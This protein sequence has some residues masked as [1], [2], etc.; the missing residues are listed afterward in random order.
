[1]KK[2]ILTLMLLAGIA[3]FSKDAFE[4]VNAENGTSY[5]QINENM[6]SF[7]FSPDWHSLGNAGRVG[8]VIYPEGLDAAQRKEY[9]SQNT[10]N[11]QF[12]KNANS[13]KIS[14]GSVSAGDRIGFYEVRPNGGTHTFTTFEDWK[15]GTWLAF[16]KNG[17][18][19]KDEWMSLGAPT[20][21]SPSSAPNGAPLP[22]A[23]S[24]IFV[25]MVG[26]TLLKK[27]KRAK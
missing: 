18:H 13:G 14:L 3:C 26:A 1:M 8:Y 16:D 17:G 6:D 15:D 10:S 22:G 7:T 25:G 24:V 9:I 20:Y 23:I 11:P 2:I 4:F 21:S 27:K 19:G 12:Q 5:I